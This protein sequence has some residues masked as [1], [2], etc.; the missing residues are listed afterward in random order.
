[1]DTM[2]AGKTIHQG[3][4]IG[5]SFDRRTARQCRAFLLDPNDPEGAVPLRWSKWEDGELRVAETVDLGSGEMAEVALFARP[6][7]PG[8]GYYI[9]VPQPGTGVPSFDGRK[10][11]GSHDFM[12]MLSCRN[13]KPV[14]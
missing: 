10:F 3:G 12:L 8:S 1:G 5:P 6:D 2:I 9:Y 4:Q 7:E 13:A 14:K 11:T